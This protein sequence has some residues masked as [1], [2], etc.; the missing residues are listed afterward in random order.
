MKGDEDACVVG[1]VGVASAAPVAKGCP[2]GASD[3]VRVVGDERLSWGRVAASGVADECV[4][5]TVIDVEE[6]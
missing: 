1:V 3:P 5:D 4:D 6:G 2:I